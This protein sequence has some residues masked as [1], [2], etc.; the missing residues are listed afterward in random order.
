[1]KVKAYAFSAVLTF[2]TSLT[3]GN[4][5]YLFFGYGVSALGMLT[6]GLLLDPLPGTAVYLLAN[7]IALGLVAYTHSAFTLLV[8]GALVVRPV[9]VYALARLRQPLGQI[10]ASLS[11]VLLGTAL[12][13]VLGLGFYGGQASD[14]P[15][16]FF[17]A[18]FVLPAYLVAKGAGGAKPEGPLLAGGVLVSALG[19]F[20]SASSFFIPLALVVS[21]VL[22]VTSGWAVVSKASKRVA[23]LLF[24]AALILVPASLAASPVAFSRDAR[25]AFYPLYL[26]SLAGNQWM[27]SNSSS[28]CKQ[29]NLAGG[30]TV[31]NGVWGPQRLRVINTCVTVS[32]TVEGITPQYGTSNDNDFGMDIK[33]DSQ[34]TSLLSVGNF[35]VGG[36][37]MH[38]EVVPS[39]QPLLTTQLHAIQPGEKITVTGVLV[40]DTDHGYGSEIHPVWAIQLGP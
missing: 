4:V 12:A 14:T 1:V 10:G 15:L 40:L 26:D 21:A 29:G 39:D 25:S 17:D 31:Q 32:G 7:A 18:F 24:I 2:V 38:A 36:G 20:M 28:V 37:L 23:A 8:V 33:L 13:T 27:Q 34:Y 11:V 5:P 22:L 30:G 35:V 16:T 9:Q 3:V 19:I 6:A